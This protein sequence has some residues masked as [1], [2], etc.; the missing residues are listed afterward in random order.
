MY[1]SAVSNYLEVIKAVAVADTSTTNAWTNTGKVLPSLNVMVYNTLSL[2][3]NKS[4][5]IFICNFPLPTNLNE[6][7]ANSVAFNT[8]KFT[9]NYYLWMYTKLINSVTPTFK[10]NVCKNYPTCSTYTTNFSNDQSSVTSFGVGDFYIQ[11]YFSFKYGNAANSVT[12]INSAGISEPNIPTDGTKIMTAMQFGV[13]TANILDLKLNYF[14][15]TVRETTAVTSCGSTNDCLPG[16]YCSNGTC[17]KCSGTCFACN[18]TSTSCTTCSRFTKE[19]KTP[20]GQASCTCK[21]L[22]S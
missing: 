14:R 11:D 10:I 20:N 9:Y 6:N 7:P 12:I 18:G 17:N 2:S 15:V 19:W 22:N 3:A 1:S 8:G 4:H 5:K 16:N 21:Y 13:N